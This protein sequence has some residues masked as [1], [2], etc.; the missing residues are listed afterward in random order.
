MIARFCDLLQSTHFIGG[1]PNLLPLYLPSDPVFFAQ[2]IRQP[3]AA[4]DTVKKTEGVA[5]V[6]LAAG[7]GAHDRRERADAQRLIG[8]ALEILHAKGSNHAAPSLHA[9]PHRRKTQAVRASATTPPRRRSLIINT[10]K[11]PHGESNGS[12]SA[13]KRAGAVRRH[14]QASRPKH[15]PSVSPPGSAGVPPANGPQARQRATPT[16]RHRRQ[17]HALTNHRPLATN[18]RP[19]RRPT[20][21]ASRPAPRRRRCAGGSGSIPAWPV[22]PIRPRPVRSSPA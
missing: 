18:H 6:A 7:I 13:C 9:C 20:A 4:P 16:A 10:P 21:A 3:I 22:P 8:E 2:Y 19:H 11:P 12:A 1:A 15:R 14:P 17:P 5:N